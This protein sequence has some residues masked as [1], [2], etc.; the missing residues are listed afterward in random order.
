[1]IFGK[2]KN[3]QAAATCRADVS[4]ADADVSVDWSTLTSQRSTSRSA[5]P[6]VSHSLEDDM[7]DPRVK[8][9]KGNRKEKGSGGLAYWAERAR[10]ACLGPMT[11]GSSWQTSLVYLGWL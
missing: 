10:S 6:P 1:M 5:D 11:G 9:V 7:W 8:K 4:G 2:R 3:T